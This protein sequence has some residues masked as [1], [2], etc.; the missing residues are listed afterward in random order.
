MHTD[1]EHAQNPEVAFEK[2]DL[3]ARG[4]ML[5]F[6]V[7]FISAATIHL[8]VWGLYEAFVNVGEAHQPPANPM[9]PR[10]VAPTPGVLQNAGSIDLK[11]FPEPRLQ[12][13]EPT[14]MNRFLWQEGQLLEAK[15]WRDQT[16]AIH[17]PIA[18]AMQIVAQKGLPVRSQP[19]N[20]ERPKQ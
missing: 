7:L 14:D 18:D 2:R 17:I 15:P 16:G 4:I 3:G 5:F 12:T 13:D 10:Q 9:V 11:H 1:P 8:V 20:Q 19:P 6:V